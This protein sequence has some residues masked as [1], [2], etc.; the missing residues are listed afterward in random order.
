V[1]P[2]I[3]HKTPKKMLAEADYRAGLSVR[4]AEALIKKSISRKMWSKKRTARPETGRKDCGHPRHL[5]ASHFGN[6]GPYVND[7]EP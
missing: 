4:A 5:K 6:S 3:C 2:V 1:I 7:T